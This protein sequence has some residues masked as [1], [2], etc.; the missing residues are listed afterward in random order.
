MER[1]RTKAVSIGSKTTR[2]KE[3]V[4]RFC[5]HAVGP[6]FKDNAMEKEMPEL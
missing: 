2:S 4:E 5:G 1:V 6:F 3:E